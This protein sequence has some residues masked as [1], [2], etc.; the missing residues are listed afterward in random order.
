MVFSTDIRYCQSHGRKILLSLGGATGTYGLSSE[1]Q[2]KKLAEDLWDMFG[3]GT[4]KTRPFGN[5]SVDGFDLDI[6]AGS[7]KGYSA[8]IERIRE[9]YSKKTSSAVVFILITRLT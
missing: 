6:E 4:S 3:G 7:A 1:D 9:L 5:V 2:G 8:F